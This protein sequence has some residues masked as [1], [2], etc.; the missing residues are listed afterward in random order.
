MGVLLRGSS[1]FVS[2]LA[3][4][5][6]GIST[7]MFTM[8][9]LFENGYRGM[10]C[11]KE[12][13]SPSFSSQTRHSCIQDQEQPL[14]KHKCVHCSELTRVLRDPTSLKDKAS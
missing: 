12:I 1:R 13:G 4:V 5:Q 8:F 2:S 14:M 11:Q 9:V 6:R 7:Y 3:S 10:S